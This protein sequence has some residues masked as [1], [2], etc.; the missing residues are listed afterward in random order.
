M[1]VSRLATY[2]PKLTNLITLH[3]RYVTSIGATQLPAG[4]KVTDPES[5][6]YEVIFSQCSLF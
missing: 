3:D 5:A 2:C 6:T 1:P 4:K